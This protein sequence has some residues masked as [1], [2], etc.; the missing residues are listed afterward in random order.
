MQQCSRLCCPRTT[1]RPTDWLTDD[2]VSYR[3]VRLRA[4][5]PSARW[6]EAFVFDKSTTRRWCNAIV[7]DTMHACSSNSSSYRRIIIDWTSTLL[8]LLT[9]LRTETIPWGVISSVYVDGKLASVCHCV[10]RIN[11]WELMYRWARQC[12]I[13]NGGDDE[14][15]DLGTHSKLSVHA[16][17]GVGC[18]SVPPIMWRWSSVET[19]SLLLI[20]F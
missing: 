19:C 11:K 5:M 3:F 1:D 15:H 20:I 14:S 7:W 4:G 16:I 8:S 17:L 9:R 13:M 6:D 12:R 2:A 10:S 18:V